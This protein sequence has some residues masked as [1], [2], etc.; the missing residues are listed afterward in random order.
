MVRLAR[1]EVI[2]PGEVAALRPLPGSW[3]SFGVLGSVGGGHPQLPSL[4]LRVMKRLDDGLGTHRLCGPANGRGQTAKGKR[5]RTPD[6]V[7]PVLR[8]LGLETSG[9]CE[10]INDFVKLFCTVAGRCSPGDAMRSHRTHRRFYLRRR[11]REL[12]AAG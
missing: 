7:P 10:L 9:W 6:R 3:W 12:M 2:D 4:T 1:C 11:A 5:G 8:R